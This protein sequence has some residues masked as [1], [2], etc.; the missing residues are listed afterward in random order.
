MNAFKVT[1]FFTEK[2]G[3]TKEGLLKTIQTDV[4]EIGLK[5][6]AFDYQKDAEKIV[7]DHVPVTQKLSKCE[8]IIEHKEFGTLPYHQLVLGGIQTVDKKYPYIDIYSINPEF[9][10]IN[11]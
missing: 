8:C 7:L 11:L 3:F 6:F 2:D 1:I 9:V 4:S 10:V 5:L